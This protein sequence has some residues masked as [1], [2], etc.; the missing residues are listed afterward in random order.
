MPTVYCFL[1]L[2]PAFREAG[3]ADTTVTI[4]APPLVVVS[5]IT[6]S[7][8]R[9]RNLPLAPELLTAGAFRETGAIARQAF[10]NWVGVKLLT[11][12]NGWTLTGRAAESRMTKN[13][14]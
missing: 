9:S 12:R 13:D 10:A 11:F 6:T 7:D 5:F 1:L 14:G 3:A 2:P 4:F 8:S